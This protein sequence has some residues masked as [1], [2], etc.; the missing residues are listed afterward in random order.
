MQ[1]EKLG[2]PP[3][4]LTPHVLLD[5]FEINTSIF[6]K[7]GQETSRS[8]NFASH[9]GD[10]G[11][12]IYKT[13]LYAAAW[14]KRPIKRRRWRERNYDH[15]ESCTPPQRINTKAAQT[16]IILGIHIISER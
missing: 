14:S 11:L 5:F 3:V 2:T 1:L 6:L 7:I 12:K 4:D 16:C 10:V 8:M 13:P 9:G 15:L